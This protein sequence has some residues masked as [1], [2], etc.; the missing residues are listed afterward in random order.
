MAV[1][2]ATVGAAL[3]TGAVPPLTAVGDAVVTLSPVSVTEWAIRTFGHDDKTVLQAGTVG[4]V[5]LLAFAVGVLA[6][7]GRRDAARAG[8]ALLGLAAALA[9]SREPHATLAGTAVV[10]GS[11]CLVGGVV[12]ENVLLP[13]M[14]V[15]DW[16]GGPYER[17]PASGTATSGEGVSRRSALRGLGL[18][19]VAVVVTG[20]ATRL[21]AAPAAALAAA[22]R[23][24]LP[25]SRAP[26]PPVP[27]GEPAG[28]SP[29]IT[30][31]AAFYRVDTALVPPAVNPSG[32]ALTVVGA[33]ASTRRIG[34]EQLLAMTQTQ[35]D[36][37]I[38]CIN[39]DVGGE[40]IGTA[41]WQGVLLPELLGL[42]PGERP[43]VVRARSVDGFVASFPLRYALDG[44]P[45]MV[46]VGMNGA[47][48]PVLHGFPARLVVPGL[49]GYTSAVKW[50]EEI[51]VVPSGLDGFWADRGWTPAV[52]VQVTSRIDW[53]AAGQRLGVGPQRIAGIAWAPPDGVGK[54]EVRI[55]DGPWRPAVLG[56]L[57]AR[58]AWRQF[59]ADW[60]ANPGPHRLACR[61]VGRDGT[62]QVARERQTF[63]SVAT[64][65][66]AVTVTAK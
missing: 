21:A 30:P 16:T 13:G 39:N 61:A 4:I 57:L 23:R 58:T 28:A 51:A 42:P 1:A 63:P 3:G 26:L 46:A 15:G 8:I 36:I 14:A 38:G 50:L 35:A 47:P 56:P 20:T 40:L 32:W 48:L 55:D 62:E 22:L 49:Y 9:S 17:G 53:P 37:T 54:V 65:I 31:L 34:Y 45:S 44:R 18:L 25:S 66:H 64:G 19:A 24:R 6:G 52:P 43:G 59:S 12:L 41:R 27:A 33:D 2:A 11:A 29:L 7:N 10:L 60:D 5:A